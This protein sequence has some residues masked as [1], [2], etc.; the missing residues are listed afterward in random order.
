[1]IIERLS[2]N[3][4]IIIERYN[5]CSSIYWCIFCDTFRVAALSQV[6]VDARNKE[7]KYYFLERVMG[8]RLHQLLGRSLLTLRVII[9]LNINTTM[10][11]AYVVSYLAVEADASSISPPG[12]GQ[13]S[14]AALVQ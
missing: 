3:H 13:G 4:Q 6:S 12:G 1:M 14:L 2:D 10:S 7:L 5:N 8:L 11:L 9:E